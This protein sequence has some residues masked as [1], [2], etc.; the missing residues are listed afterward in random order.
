MSE[1]TAR[2]DEEEGRGD[3]VS[4]IF[5][6]RIGARRVLIVD[7]EPLIGTTLRMLLDEHHVTV[8]ASGEEAMSRI[9]TEA[10]DL[11][12]CDLMLDDVAGVE[13]LARVR[14]VR[15][16]LAERVVFMTGGAYT[17]EAKRFLSSVPRSR[18][19]DKPFS[20]SEV[21]AVLRLFEPLS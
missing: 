18:R 4:S 15:P 1:G 19:L 21:I 6:R 10:F 5:P 11:V 20:A 12:L 8:A 9:E 14:R 2:N 3:R 16:E 7:D 17:A 13:L